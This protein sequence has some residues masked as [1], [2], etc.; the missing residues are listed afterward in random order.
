M[1]ATDTGSGGTPVNLPMPATTFARCYS[2]VDFGTAESFYNNES[3]GKKRKCYVT[4]E[5]PEFKAVFAEGRQPEPFV[6]GEE[7]SVTTSDNGNLSK[8]ITAWRGFGFTPEEKVDF[9]VEKM[10]GKPCIMAF[11]LKQ[12]Q[13]IQ[14]GPNDPWTNKNARLKKTSIA[15]MPNGFSEMQVTNQP[16][17]FDFDAM[18]VSGQFD[19]ESFKR[20]PKWQRDRIEKSDEFLYFVSLGQIQAGMDFRNQQ[21]APPPQAAQQPMTPQQAYPAPQ[22]NPPQA[23]PQQPQAQPQA[24]P[25]QTAPPQQPPAQNPPPAG[26]Q[27]PSGW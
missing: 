24:Q 15:P 25:Q 1:K 9:P 3:Q 2:V 16:V 23:P 17:L 5:L 14:K 27:G 8:L 20:L 21:Q 7:L 10:L 4:W 12:K 13:N 19:I 6:I 26:G 11:E 22:A 18:M